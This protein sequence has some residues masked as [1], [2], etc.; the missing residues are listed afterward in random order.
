MYKHYSITPKECMN[1]FNNETIIGFNSKIVCPYFQNI[2]LHEIRTLHAR[3]D[4]LEFTG[5]DITLSIGNN[6][7]S[8]YDIDSNNAFLWKINEK[9]TLFIP[10]R[11]NIEYGFHTIEI[12]IGIK[13]TVKL[14]SKGVFDSY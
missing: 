8:V 14:S 6:I 9:A 2:F 7:F 3:V 4:N 5:D 12:G 10:Y 1:V 13:H 11:E